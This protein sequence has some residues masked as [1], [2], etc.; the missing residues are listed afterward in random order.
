MSQQ[1]KQQPVF[2]TDTCDENEDMRMF[3]ELR[4]MYKE[5]HPEPREDDWLDDEQWYC[6]NVAVWTNIDIPDE[7]F[8]DPYKLYLFL[9]ERHQANKEKIRKPPVMRT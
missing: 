2:E 5:E 3:S 7:V 1:K 8:H 4:K 6:E 9:Y